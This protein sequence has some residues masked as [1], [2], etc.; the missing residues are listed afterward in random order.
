MSDVHKTEWLGLASGTYAVTGAGSGIGAAVARQLL[1]AGARVALLDLNT[2]GCQSLVEAEAAR[3][4]SLVLG[5]DIGDEA[6]VASAAAAIAGRFGQLDGLVNCA[7]ILRA[8][9]LLEVSLDDWNRVLQVNLTGSLMCARALVPL[10]T[11]AGAAALVFIASVA[12]L[13][14]QTRSGAYSASKAGVTL[15]SRQLAVELAAQR[16]RSNVI[17]PGMIRTALSEPFYAHPGITEAREQMTA[18]G[19]IG[20]PEDI[21]NAALFLLSERSSYIN[22]TELVVDGGLDN[23]LMHLIPRPGFSAKA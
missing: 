5:C 11:Q 3:E 12:A 23:M 4:R 10:M 8:G 7:G 22:G 6:S 21:A 19:R 15:L 17:C 20:R 13:M 1:Q 2:D 14:P 16:I 18:S 9:P